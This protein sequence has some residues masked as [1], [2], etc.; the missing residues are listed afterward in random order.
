MLKNVDRSSPSPN[1]AKNNQ[2]GISRLFNTKAFTHNQP[3]VRPVGRKVSQSAI[4]PAKFSQ[5]S[6]SPC[7][8]YNDSDA[9]QKPPLSRTRVGVT[10]CK[11]RT[12]DTTHALARYDVTSCVARRL[13]E[14]SL[15]KHSAVYALETLSL[16]VE[17]SDERYQDERVLELA[18]RTL[19]HLPE[20][21]FRSL[22]FLVLGLL[23]G[24]LVVRHG[25]HEKE[26]DDCT[27]VRG[28][29]HVGS[30]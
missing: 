24:L 13:I 26:S 17:T 27:H 5:L 28:R 16:H 18:K 9:E 4:Y 6:D 15:G 30:C 11:S 10:S 22:L 3:A 21:L 1:A 7:T 8:H 23:C 29:D 2:T 19:A 12:D 25:R 20:A 14:Q